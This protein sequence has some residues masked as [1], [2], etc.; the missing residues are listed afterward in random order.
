MIIVVKHNLP[1]TTSGKKGMETQNPDFQQSK[2]N[3]P[4]NLTVVERLK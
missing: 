1:G 3:Q 2:E 4:N